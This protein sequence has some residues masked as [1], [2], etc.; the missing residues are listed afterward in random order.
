MSIDLSKY[1]NHTYSPE[2]KRA[3][4]VSAA[5]AV[6]QSK[7]ANAPDNA[8]IVE[9]ELGRLSEYADLIQEALKVT[10]E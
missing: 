7:T 3:L 5:L 2:D 9:R 10:A 1:N 6:I 4:A 8:V